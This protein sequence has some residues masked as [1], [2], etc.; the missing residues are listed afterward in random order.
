MNVLKSRDFTLADDPFVLFEAWQEDARI[1]EPNDPTA[2]A[3]STVDGDGLPD[4]RMVLLKG[5]DRRGF[6]FYTNFES[7]KGRELQASMKAAALFHWK[8][9][10]RQ[11]RIRGPI[12]VVSDAEADAYYDSRPRQSRIGAW[13]SPQSQPLKDRAELEAAFATYD[14]KHPGEMI[15]RPPHWSG[16]RIKPTAIEFWSDGAHRLHD[17]ILFARDTVDDGW[18]KT[19]L[20]P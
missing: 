5:V 11:I 15:P 10:R 14:A 17:R 16:F 7:A 8:S 2:M 12:E 18:S 13:A 6:V 3:L 20:A 19:R 4:V 1:G 9:L